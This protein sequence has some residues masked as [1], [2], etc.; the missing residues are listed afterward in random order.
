MKTKLKFL[1]VAFLLFVAAPMFALTTTEVVDG[2]TAGQVVEWLTP[3]VVL[4]LTYVIR[5]LLPL[6]PSW[7]TLLVV[8]ALSGMVAWITSILTDVTDM[9]FLMQVGYGLLAIVINQFYKAF[10]TKENKE[11]K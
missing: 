6:I 10:S 1:L 8:T 11:Y 5:L 9:T 2:P 3:F 7:A 4:G